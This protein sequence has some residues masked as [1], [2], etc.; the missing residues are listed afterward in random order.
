MHTVSALYKSVIGYARI[1]DKVK[2]EVI[3]VKPRK[4]DKTQGS[5]L[6]NNFKKQKQARNLEL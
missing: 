1:F 6:M 5:V 3:F 2:T 4:N